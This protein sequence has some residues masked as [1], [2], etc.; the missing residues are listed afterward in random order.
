M[1]ALSDII[2]QSFPPTPKFT[3][4]NVPDL[5][6]QVIIVTGGTIGIGRETA[7]TLLS[8]NATVYIA[9]RNET[10]VVKELKEE[11]GKE[12]HFLKLDLA[13]LKAVKAAAEEFLSKETSLH[14]LFNNAGVMEP[15]IE[16]LTAD[17]Y[18][19]Q[20][21]TNVIG[22]YYFTK[23]LLPLMVAT[24]KSSGKASRVIHTSSGM[25]LLNTE[26]DV[27]KLARDGPARK[28][29]GVSKLYAFSKFNTVLFAKELSRRYGDQGIVSIS[30][31]PGVIK[32]DLHRHMKG[33][34]GLIVGLL[35]KTVLHDVAHGAITQLYAGTS[36]EA[37]EMN[38]AYLIPWA[39]VGK[40]NP[41]TQDPK[42]GEALWK[43]LDEQVADI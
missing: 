40:P 24:A 7:K 36:P 43:W 12:A 9:S 30:L 19:M 29:T 23:L 31:H 22:P 14:V 2:A 11:T 8:R 35:E 5:D 17:G 10:N 16:S 13:N 39:R 18:D 34:K 4:A 28:K 1:G 37:A 26:T 21:G 25:H 6:G 33:P 38:G 20:L 3:A 27:T 32:T 41:A 42:N 15:P